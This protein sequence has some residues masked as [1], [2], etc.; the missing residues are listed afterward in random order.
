M[1]IAYIY[2][3]FNQNRDEKLIISTNIEAVKYLYAVFL[4]IAEQRP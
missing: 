1:F 2:I 4:L 3:C